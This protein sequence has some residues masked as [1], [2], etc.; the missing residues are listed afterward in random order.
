MAIN[1]VYLSVA[2]YLALHWICNKIYDS[3]L[4]TETCMNEIEQLGSPKCEKKLG[5]VVIA[6]GR[7]G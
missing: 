4:A 2:I 7:Y 3:Q 6:G 5:T 1:L